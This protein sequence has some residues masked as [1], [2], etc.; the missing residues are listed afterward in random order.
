MKKIGQFH[1]FDNYAGRWEIIDEIKDKNIKIE[2]RLEDPQ[3]PL[4]VCPHCGGSLTSKK[5]YTFNTIQ[6]LKQS[7]AK[8][9]FG[10]SDCGRCVILEEYLG[11][12]LV[13]EKL[14]DYKT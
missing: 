11:F 9:H 7:K 12:G 1:K 5:V 14:N 3:M 8:M 2:L 10:I 13:E 6:I 4:Q